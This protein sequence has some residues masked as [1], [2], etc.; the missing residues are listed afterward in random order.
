MT[1]IINIVL[2]GNTIPRR[3][4]FFHD[5]RWMLVLHGG[6]CK[7]GEP[8]NN[9]FPSNDSAEKFPKDPPIRISPSSLLKE[10]FRSSRYESF[11]KDAGIAPERLLLDK[12]KDFKLIKSP[13]ESRIDPCNL[14]YP[15]KRYSRFFR[16]PIFVGITPEKLFIEKS[17]PTK[18]FKFPISNGSG[19]VKKFEEKLRYK[20]SLRFQKVKGIEVNSLE[21][22]DSILREARLLKHAGIDPKSLLPPNSKSYNSVKRQILS[23]IDPSNLLSSRPKP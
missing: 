16:P 23:G 21:P 3:R 10:R 9:S 15:K 20:I 8:H 5:V 13:N 12:F 7:L 18:T 4:E 14:L 17:I 6:T 11:S 22:N 19:A 2:N 1:T